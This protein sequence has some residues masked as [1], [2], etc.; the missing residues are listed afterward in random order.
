V[1]AE[2][3]AVNAIVKTKAQTNLQIKEMFGISR[4]QNKEKYFSPAANSKNC[5][6]L[7]LMNI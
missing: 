3:K 2:V 5:L 1:S 6:I 4:K 7:F